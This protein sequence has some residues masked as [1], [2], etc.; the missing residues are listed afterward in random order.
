MDNPYLQ[1]LQSLE[2]VDDFSIS[3]IRAML[4]EIVRLNP[5]EKENAAL[6]KKLESTVGNRE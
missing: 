4:D 2:R 6:K 3:D 1:Y 5:L